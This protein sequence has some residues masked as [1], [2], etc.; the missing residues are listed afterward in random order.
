MGAAPVQP[1]LS[2]KPQARPGPVRD[3]VRK[4]VAGAPHRKFLPRAG[5]RVRALSHGRPF[6][7]SAPDER[8]A[9]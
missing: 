4:P 2:D 9:G 5:A 3:A 7:A 1:S 8:C 6:A